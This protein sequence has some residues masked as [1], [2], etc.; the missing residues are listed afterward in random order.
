MELRYTCQKKPTILSKV[1]LPSLAHRER[2][3]G[4]QPGA[5][6]LGLSCLLSDWPSSCSG[7]LYF[8]LKRQEALLV[9]HL[10]CPPAPPLKLFCCLHT[11]VHCF[12]D[13][14]GFQN[15]KARTVLA[16][17]SLCHRFLQTYDNSC[18][19]FMGGEDLETIRKTGSEEYHPLKRN[20]SSSLYMPGAVLN[21]LHALSHFSLKL[22]I[23]C[24]SKV[25]SYQRRQ[26]QPTP[27]LLPGKY[28][29][30]RSLVGC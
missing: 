6:I 26:C 30:R 13:F 10:G 25:N 17:Y 18:L 8:C 15:S 19:N 20:P 9:Q 7:K 1:L 16:L 14:L 3:H 21:T 12:P 27:V 24:L 2:H 5:L 22:E 23:E 28:H 4:T 29:G 11:L